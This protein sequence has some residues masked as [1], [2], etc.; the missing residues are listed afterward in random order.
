MIAALLNIISY[1]LTILFWI[2]I[3]QVVISWL[4]VFRVLDPYNRTVASIV[5]FL[6]RV[7]HPIYRPIR[8][9]L[10]DFGGIDL[11]PMVVIFGIIVLRDM[12]L[13][14]ILL[15]IGPTITR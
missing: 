1:A 7:T 4:F 5:E 8:K 12:V 11:S 15:E 13:P 6:E 3:A 14:G 2:I 9:L 10:P